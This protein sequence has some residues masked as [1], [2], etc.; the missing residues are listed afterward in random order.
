MN[1]RESCVLLWIQPNTSRNNEFTKTNFTK[2]LQTKRDLH[3]NNI[4]RHHLK[5]VYWIGGTTC[6]GKTTAEKHNYCHYDADTMFNE[7]RKLATSGHQTA[8]SKEIS[9]L[10]ECFKRPID[11]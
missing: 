4:L 5:N 10:I 11:E 2:I 3:E 7:F 1:K 6:G 8:L 9:N